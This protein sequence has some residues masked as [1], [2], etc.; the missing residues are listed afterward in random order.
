MDIASLVIGIVA[1]VLGMIPCINLF[2]VLPAIIGLVLGV[3]S[4]V[5]KSK[6]NEPKGKAISGLIL[7]ILAL[8]ITFGMYL[9]GSYAQK[10]KKSSIESKEESRYAYDD[11]LKKKESNASD[12]SKADERDSKL[13]ISD[14]SEPEELISV[15]AQRL[16]SDY[17]SNEVNADS[18]Y[19]GKNLEVSGTIKSI[20]KDIL[21]DPYI[22][23]KSGGDFEI[24][25]V[26]CFFDDESEL[27]SL[28]KGQRV[29]VIGTCDGKFGN[30]T[31]KNC[32]LKR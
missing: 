9:G 32:Q 4:A 22:T 18:K 14:L 25:S 19:K 8:F 20:G 16:F 29:T 12:K 6:T 5:Q 17:E 11:W 27:A 13:S 30:V 26:Q 21:D 28:K 23:L 31:L 7:N 24:F 10:E 15:S 1:I 2:A 3:V